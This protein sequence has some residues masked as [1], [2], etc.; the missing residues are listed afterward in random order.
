MYQGSVG[1]AYNLQE[2]QK[3]GIT[4]ILTCATN[5]G[6]RFP[7]E[8]T[9]EVLPLL[10]TPTQNI[11]NYFEQA[12]NFINSCKEKKGKILVHCFAGKSRASTITISYLMAV[13]KLDFRQSLDHLKRQRP[14]AQPNI[15]FMVQLKNYE[16]QLFGKCSDV[17]LMPLT[18]AVSS[19]VKELSDAQQ[20]L[21]E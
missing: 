2:L 15:G 13:L 17:R 11:M 16:M 20:V 1:T 14:I 18:G 21:N 10:D 5:I 12:Q 3:L 7:A 8:F 19:V 6:K 9:Y 4:H